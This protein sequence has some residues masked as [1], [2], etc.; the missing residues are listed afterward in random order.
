MGFIKRSWRGETKLWKVFWLGGI[1]VA[2]G[3]GILW[4]LLA[5]SSLLAVILLAGIMHGWLFLAVWRCAFN[6]GWRMWGYI[7]RVLGVIGIIS[8][9]SMAYFGYMVSSAQN[10]Q[11]VC[12]REITARAKATGT[13]LV[14]AELKKAME[15]C[16]KSKGNL[17]FSV[18]FSYP[19]QPAKLSARKACEKT[20]R[21][22]AAKGGA[23]PET[24]VAQNEAWIE[25]CVRQRLGNSDE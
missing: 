8:W 16:L 24:Y 17:E 14:G 22:H 13:M 19:D 5:G 10:A 1:V 21:A 4:A 3:E 12:M 25:Q 15:D 18:E 2:I 6:C 11:M 9:L 23:E 20:L 7:A